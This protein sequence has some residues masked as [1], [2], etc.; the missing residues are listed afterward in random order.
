MMMIIMIMVVIAMNVIVNFSNRNW[1]VCVVMV[2]AEKMRQHFDAR[3]EDEDS[4]AQA[5]QDTSCNLIRVVFD[6]DATGNTDGNTDSEEQHKKDSFELVAL[7][8]DGESANGETFE[9]LVNDENDAKNASECVCFGDSERDADDDGVNENADF[10]DPQLDARTEAGFLVLIACD[11]LRLLDS[12][13]APP[14]DFSTDEEDRN[15]RDHSEEIREGIGMFILFLGMSSL[16]GSRFVARR[17]RCGSVLMRFDEEMVS[18]FCEFRDTV[19]KKVNQRGGENDTE[20]NTGEDLDDEI[21]AA[22]LRFAC[23]LVV[24]LRDEAV[25]E[26]NGRYSAEKAGEE[27]DEDGENLEVENGKRRIVF[28]AHFINFVCF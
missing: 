12:A 18:A 24:V 11:T 7:S 14:V 1:P 13:N 4:G 9:K 23:F 2:R 22:F 6:A 15:E 28:S 27:D 19:R 5:E 20:R 10:S 21:D 26:C 16:S 8:S 25:S 17:S 3:N